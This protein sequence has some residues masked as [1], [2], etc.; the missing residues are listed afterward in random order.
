MFSAK[1]SH[2]STYMSV[3]YSDGMIGIYSSYMGDQIYQ[4]KDPDIHYPITAISWKPQAQKEASLQ[5]FKGVG[6]D[7]RIVMWRPKFA[8]Q[9]QTLF[10]SATNSY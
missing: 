2:D 7:G 8:N 9:L 6:S 10:V 4:I 1:F 3:A 5:T